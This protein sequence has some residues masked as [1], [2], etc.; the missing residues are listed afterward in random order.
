MRMLGRPPALREPLCLM[1][2]LGPAST[3]RLLRGSQ[4]L[5]LFQ[6]YKWIAAVVGILLTGAPLLWLTSWLQRQ[7][8]AEVSITANWSVGITDLMINQAVTSLNDLASRNVDSCQPVHVE[9]LRRAVFASALIREISFV[10]ASG[11][12]LCTDN[13]RAAM[14]RDVLASAATSKAGIMLDVVGLDDSNERL[15][16]VRRLAPRKTP[17][18]AALLRPNLLLPQVTPDGSPFAGYARMTLADGTVIGSSGSEDALNDENLVGH[19]KSQTYGQIVT[20]VMQRGGRIANYDDLRRI[21]MVVSGMIVSLNAVGCRSRVPRTF[22]AS[23]RLPSCES[24]MLRI[25]NSSPPMRNT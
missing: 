1:Q 14:T 23:R 24:L 7:G 8:E 13:G 18:L 10:D 15:L 16:R 20:V 6:R 12:T 19:T 9:Q 5:A 11:Q 22:S 2:S 3:V 25:R 4:E 17:M 21:G